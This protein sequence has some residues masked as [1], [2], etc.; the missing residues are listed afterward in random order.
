MLGRLVGPGFR[1][2]HIGAAVGVLLGVLPGVVSAHGGIEELDPRIVGPTLAAGVLLFIG[3]FGLMLTGP[4]W[5]L[6][7]PEETTITDD[8]VVPLPQRQ[9]NTLSISQES[10]ISEEEG[11]RWRGRS[12][13]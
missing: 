9:R 5:L 11:K 6:G 12:A 8:R 1:R 10:S 13:G 7:L 2:F 3:L 4:A